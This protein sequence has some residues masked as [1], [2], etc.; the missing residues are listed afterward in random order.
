MIDIQ[1]LY[2]TKSHVARMLG[3]QK[4]DIS[5]LIEIGTLSGYVQ[6]GKVVILRRDLM[7]YVNYHAEFY[8][9]LIDFLDKEYS[10]EGNAPRGYCCD[11]GMPLTERNS[12]MEVD[13]YFE[14]EDIPVNI[15]IPGDTIT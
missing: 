15:K 5:K 3:I 8:L 14:K 13:D 4:K 1:E 11:S 7:D 9:D 10:I 6:G 12:I 2:F